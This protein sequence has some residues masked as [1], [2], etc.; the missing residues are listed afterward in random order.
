MKKKTRIKEFEKM[1]KSLT[2][3]DE[4]QKVIRKDSLKKMREDKMKDTGL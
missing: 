2:D 4:I 3:P 1:Y